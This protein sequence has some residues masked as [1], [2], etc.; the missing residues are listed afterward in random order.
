VADVIPRIMSHQIPQEINLNI[1]LTII[2]LH[3]LKAGCDSEE[4][5]EVLCSSEV[6]QCVHKSLPV[7]PVLNHVGPAHTIA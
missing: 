1:S 7:V 2:C 5:T 6:D 3:K 4:T